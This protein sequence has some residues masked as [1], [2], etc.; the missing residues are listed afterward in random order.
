[1]KSARLI[2]T[3][4][5]GFTIFEA[6][7]EDESGSI[8]AV[9]FN[10]PYLDRVFA[11]GKLAVFY[12]KAG[13]DRYKKNLILPNPE[14]EMLESVDDEGIHTGRIV[15]VYRKQGDL[16][17]RRVRALIFRALRDLDPASLPERIPAEVR[18]RY[19]LMSRLEALRYV[20]VPPRDASLD[21]LEQRDSPAHH[22]L[23]FEEAFLLQLA[24]AVRRQGMQEQERGNAYEISDAMRTRFARLLPFEL[25]AAQKRVLGEIGEDLRGPTPMY[26]LVQGDVGSG[27]TIVALL[28]ML[29]AVE[30]GYQAALMAP[31]EI[32]A[33]QH[34]RSLMALL[35]VEGVDYRVALLT[36]SLKGTARKRVLA[37]IESGE[38]QVVVGTHALFEPTVVFSRL[39]LTVV[40]EQHRFGVMQRAALASKGQRPDVLVMTATPIPRSLAL[41]L[42][43][44]LDVSVI[45]ELP[46]GRIPPATV[47]RREAQR[48]R[49]H[50]GIRLEVQKGRQAYVVVPLVEETE[51]SDLKAAT[52]HTERL[53]R[54]LPELRIGMVHGRMKSDEK[55]RT[56]RAFAGG[57]LDVLVATTVIEVGVDVPNAT[58]MI[59][60]HAERFGLSQLHQLRGRVGRGA[61]R[62]FCVLMV[63]DDPQSKDAAERLK[64][65][66]RQSDGFKIAEKDLELRGPGAVFGTQQH[67]LSD[68]QFL[69]LVMRSPLLLEGAR[70]EARIVVEA[71][72]D[73]ARKRLQELPPMWRKRLR[74]AEVG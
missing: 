16:N 53:R 20:H 44:D 51:K 18:E 62:S 22:S 21:G 33:E 47:V 65:M 32:L 61:E 31:T 58:V 23:A 1:M 5:R 69:A 64:V 2:R 57:E 48:E 26:R 28:A 71:S 42:Y 52:A 24:L 49:V 6:M 34:F 43:G 63:G 17:P 39:G 37:Q 36:G 66:E 30:N 50:G 73:D 10:Q 41:T 35:G 38:A 19:A 12:G 45:D 7:L 56:M 11:A 55:D 14:Y 27:K 46:P 60:E 4:R 54:E 9:W 74:L 25:T 15:G 40:D 29:V 70:T 72:L 8:K 68:L 3:R 13:L 59:I 67:G